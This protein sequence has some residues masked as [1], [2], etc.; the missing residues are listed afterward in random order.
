MGPEAIA[1]FSHD[2]VFQERIPLIVSSNAPTAFFATTGSCFASVAGLNFGMWDSTL[3]ARVGVQVQTAAIATR[4]LQDSVIS[5]AT[6]GTGLLQRQTLSLTFAS[7]SYTSSLSSAKVKR[8][9]NVAP[10]TFISTG[11]QILSIT[12]SQFGTDSKSSTIT[13]LRS[14]AP[15]SVWVSDSSALCKSSA[16]SAT[17]AATNT[18]VILSV[19]RSVSLSQPQTGSVYAVQKPC[20]NSVNISNSTGRA[21]DDDPVSVLLFAI[22]GLGCADPRYKLLV[23]KVA[24][25]DTIWASDSSMSCLYTKPVSKDRVQLQIDIRM[26]DEYDTTPPPISSTLIPNPALVPSSRPIATSFMSAIFLP[27]PHFVRERV[28][29]YAGPVNAPPDFCVESNRTVYRYA[30]IL[31]IDVLFYCNHTQVYL[32]NFL[33]YAIDIRGNFSIVNTQNGA[34]LS[35]AICDGSSALFHALPSNSFATVSRTSLVVCPKRDVYSAF[36]RLKFVVMNETGAPIEFTVDSDPF[37]LLTSTTFIALA[38]S[39]SSQTPFSEYVAGTDVFNHAFVIESSASCGR[40]AVQYIA[41]L[42]CLLANG[43]QSSATPYYINRTRSI[44]SLSATAWSLRTCTINISGWVFFA[45]GTCKVALGMPMFPGTV[46]QS[47]SFAVVGGLPSSL[48]VSGNI[49]SR[50]Q[51]GDAIRSL[52]ASISNCLS[53]FLFDEFNNSVPKCQ[54]SF[55]ISAV[56][57]NETH[58]TVYALFGPT[59]GFSDCKGTVSW[60]DTRTPSP[61]TIRL[62]VL[63]PWFNTT[64][65]AIINVSG[66][67]QPARIMVMSNVTLNQ[68]T[69]SGGASIPPI[70]IQLTNAVGKPLLSITT[71]V[72]IRI[73]IVPKATANMYV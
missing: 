8:S 55:E 25:N 33:P 14:A 28:D 60:C 31:D 68:S 72:V 64:L 42:Q 2:L 20:A 16:G 56:A 58:E 51:E 45:A 21:G 39:S 59:S 7:T 18:S 44:T 73:R 10:D 23:E 62:S 12:G 40:I 6:K 52:N 67:G 34:Q 32:K 71:A 30:E 50:L 54:N 53:V 3:R 36:L 29:S 70:T 46:L 9:F 11:A 43:T 37:E 57:L 38:P 61:A 65:S 35:D 22:T 41:T 66:Q 27:M 24:C 5:L 69:L 63:S 49:S 15:F 4:W 17:S 1:L 19:D 26:R 13:I 48:R 47:P